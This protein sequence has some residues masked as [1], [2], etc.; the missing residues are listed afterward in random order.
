[1]GLNN[2]NTEAASAFL[3]QARQDASAARKTKR[4]EGEWV[5]TEGET[6]F[7]ASV[8]FQAGECVLESDFAP[9]MG[10]HGLAPDPIQYCLYGLAA[11]YAA[12]FVSIATTEGL[13]L[14]SLKVAVE[15]VVNLSRSLGLS[16]APVVEGVDVTLSVAADASRERLEAIAQLARDRCP[17][18]YC[19]VHPIRL[20]TH[21]EIQGST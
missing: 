3:A 21:L 5:F 17:G 4:V 7:K 16:S 9:F 19:L 6:Q 10:G 2:F 11:C 13:K 12:T 1:M 15:N 20:T 18:V 8:A 14:H